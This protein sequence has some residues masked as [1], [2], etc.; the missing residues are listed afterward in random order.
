[1]RQRIFTLIGQWRLL[2][3]LEIQCTRIAIAWCCRYT[4]PGDQI[5]W[6]QEKEKGVSLSS[7]SVLPLSRPVVQ[8]VVALSHDLPP[9]GPSFSEKLLQHPYK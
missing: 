1:M 4:L 9:L 3:R 6:N 7:P 8:Q 2:E 5:V